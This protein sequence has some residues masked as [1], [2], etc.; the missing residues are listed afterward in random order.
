MGR[1]ALS[2]GLISEV[3]KDGR[4]ALDRH[5]RKRARQHGIEFSE[6]VFWKKKPAA[7]ALGKLSSAWSFGAF[8]GA[9]GLSGEF[10]VS[11]KN[12][13]WKTRTIQ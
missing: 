9:R 8:V 1:G 12:G 10:I 7:G 2:S 4:T 3:G 13:V 11:D 5:R 6:G